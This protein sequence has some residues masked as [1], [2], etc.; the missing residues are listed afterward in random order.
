MDRILAVIPVHNRRETT[1]AVLANLRSLAATAFQLDILIIDDGSTDGTSEAV[2]AQF[3]DV[4]MLQGDGNLWWGGALNVGFRYGLE[5]GYDYIY[6]LND[7]IVLRTDTLDELHNASKALL[8]TV[9]CSICLKSDGVIL[10]ADFKF[11]GILRIPKKNIRDLPYEDLHQDILVSDTISTRSTLIPITVLQQ[12]LFI[13][14]RQFPHNY[15]DFEYFYRITKH[16]FKLAVIRKSIIYS[17][18]SSS[19]YH[20]L[21]IDKSSTEILQTFFNIKYAHNLRTQWNLACN[22]TTF[23]LRI[24]RFAGLMTPYVTWLALKVLL[25]KNFLLQLLIYYDKVSVQKNKSM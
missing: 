15:S 10:T 6:T 24:F 11:S 19:N 9:C 13:D 8:D 21:I 2:K 12:N 4:V 17:T 14:N 18:E 25:P 22:N 3:P 16:G 20:Y 5:H 7:D 1:L 23:V